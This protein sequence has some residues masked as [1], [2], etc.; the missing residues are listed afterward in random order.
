[1]NGNTPISKRLASNIVLMLIAFSFYTCSSE[2]NGSFTTDY[3]KIEI[4]A[5]GFITSM[6]DITKEPYREFSP[7][8]KPS[9]LMQLYDGKNKMYYQPIAANFD[10]AN[11]SLTLS[12]ANGSVA[13]ILL[14][15]EE[16]YLKLTL[17]SLSPRNGIDGIQWGPITRISQTYLEK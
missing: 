10:Q 15:P 16:K 7:L 3:F 2:E 8:D 1:M 14:S 5:N 13:Q 11:H 9:P 12:Y 17:Q 6:I 4:N